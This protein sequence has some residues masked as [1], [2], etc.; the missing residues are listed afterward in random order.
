MAIIPV[1]YYRAD[2][3]GCGQTCVDD[4]SGGHVLGASPAKALH[5]AGNFGYVEHRGKLI[6][7][8]C[9]EQL[10]DQEHDYVPS[11]PAC[12]I[13]GDV[14]T[15]AHPNVPMPGQTAL[16]VSGVSV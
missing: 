9:A 11:G 4:D 6:C 5:H 8:H 12:A 13:C 15:A 2:C 3:D 16:G 10:A 1:T 14:P 7:P